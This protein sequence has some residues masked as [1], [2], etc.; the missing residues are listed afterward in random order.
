MP[1][2]PARV[3]TSPNAP[4]R[5]AAARMPSLSVAALRSLHA[6]PVRVTQRPFAHPANNPR[7]LPSRPLDIPQ[8]L[9]SAPAT[10]PRVPAAPPIA[11][12]A[13]STMSAR[14]QQQGGRPGGSRFAQFK[15]VLLGRWRLM[16]CLI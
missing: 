14:P 4:A 5:A 15:L 3:P 9:S 13:F 12:R 6:R 11:R 8:T 2:R 16:L 7:H 1:P 10:P